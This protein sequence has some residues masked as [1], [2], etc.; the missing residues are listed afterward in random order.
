L[1]RA[2]S[3]AAS[4]YL[5]TG[6]AVTAEGLFQTAVEKAGGTDP[7]SK[8]AHHEAYQNY[9]ELCRQWENRHSD[10]ERLAKESQSI[11]DSL[12]EAWKN[13]PSIISGL[14]FGDM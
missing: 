13:K 3:L 5:R 1:G 2:L 8:I 9:S 10:S 12:P 7:L 11:H 6:S 4:C 14:S